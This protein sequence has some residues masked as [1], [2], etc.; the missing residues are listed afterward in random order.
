MHGWQNGKE[1]CWPKKIDEPQMRTNF[2][3][4]IE[5]EDELQMNYRR[6]CRPTGSDGDGKTAP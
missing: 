1:G 6:H 5:N 3:K 4:T 2:L